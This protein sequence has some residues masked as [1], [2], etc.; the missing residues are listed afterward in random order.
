MDKKI[1]STKEQWVDWAIKLQ[2]IAQ[3]GLYYTKNIYEK[4]RYEQIREIACEILETHSCINI[5]EIEEYF[6]KDTGYKTPKMD[7]RAV[8]F[9]GNKILLVQEKNGMWSIPGGWVDIDQTL[10]SNLIKEAKE[11][12]GADVVP[13]FV[14]ALHDWKSHVSVKFKHLPFQIC[15]IFVMCKL[16]DINFKMNSETLQANFFDFDHLPQNIALGKNTVEQIK[17]CF[18]ANDT[19]N[20]NKSWTTKFD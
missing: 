2:A 10:S 15:K 14:I 20:N 7:S 13:Q 9:K 1:I 11:E 16:K 3:S 6:T 4:E 12:A 5:E 19:T 17:L 8:C 18:E